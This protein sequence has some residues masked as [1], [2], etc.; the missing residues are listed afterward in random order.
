MKEYGP[1]TIGTVVP[2]PDTALLVEAVGGLEEVDEAGN[3]GGG[4]GEEDEAGAEPEPGG[5]IDGIL[6]VS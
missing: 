1:D 6:A 2:A 5:G 4:G 3:V